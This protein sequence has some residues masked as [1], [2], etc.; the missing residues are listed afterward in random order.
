MLRKHFINESIFTNSD[1]ITPESSYILGLMWADGT[2]GKNDYSCSITGI[3]EDIDTLHDIFKATGSWGVYVRPAKG[4]RKQQTT[5]QY[6][7]KTFH[8][9][10]KSKN[11]HIKSAESAIEILQHIPIQL[12]CYWWRGFFDGDGCIHIN[13]NTQLFFT[14]SINQ[15]WDYFELLPFNLNWKLI[16][17][18]T[19]NGNYSRMLIQSKSSVLQFFKFIYSDKLNIG[20]SR[21][22]SKLNSLT[23]RKKIKWRGKGYYLVK[24]LN[25]W[26]ASVEL[27]GNRYY[28]GL[29]INEIDAQ[30][31]VSVKRAEL[32][33]SVESSIPD[34]SF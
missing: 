34:D 22:Y 17:K 14:G 2:L 31:A 12:Q 21:K 3:S 32:E 24:G 13:K 15:C 5:F 6:N 4:V 16:Q 33:I 28:L 9:F 7:S 18:K 27:D 10:L 1:Q 11:Y 8:S 26:Y 19:S 23:K 20:L 30:S 29:F 25:K